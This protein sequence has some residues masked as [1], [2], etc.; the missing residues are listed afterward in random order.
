MRQLRDS[1]KCEYEPTIRSAMM[2]AKTLKG[3]ALTI[4]RSNG[5]FA[6]ICQD[7]FASQTSR[8]GSKTN[9]NIVREY[10]AGLIE[11]DLESGLPAS[12]GGLRGIRS[13]RIGART[14]KAGTPTRHPAWEVK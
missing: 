12:R 5:F 14:E 6:K 11:N 13:G 8:V 1:G 2:I 3:D 10:V 4:A 7:I 9:Q